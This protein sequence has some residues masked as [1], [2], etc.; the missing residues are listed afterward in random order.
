[1]SWYFNTV[2]KK[3]FD[4]VE[5]QVRDALDR[6]GFGVL[7]SIPIHEKLKMTIGQDFHRYLILGACNP[8]NA[9]KALQAEDKIGLMLPCN[10]I[11]QQLKDGEVEVAAV[12][13]VASM[14]AVNNPD[15][16]ETADFI[17]NKLKKV[18]DSLD[19]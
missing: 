8:P 13:P 1:M 17:R 14:M 2:V 16:M 6:E 19:Q 10:L 15:L 7:T 11:I 5:Q 18:I 9:Y 12:D 3:P 4:E